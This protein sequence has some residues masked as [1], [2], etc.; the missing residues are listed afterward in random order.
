MSETLLIV[1][2]AVVLVGVA[3]IVRRAARS[4]AT[5][6]DAGGTGYVDGTSGNYGSDCVDTGGG[7]DGGGGGGGD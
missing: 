3:W 5:R 7:C 6:G 4:G 1:A 2:G